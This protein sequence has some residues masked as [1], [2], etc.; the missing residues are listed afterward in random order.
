VSGTVSSATVIANNIS[1][2]T[3]VSTATVFASTGIITNLSVLSTIS[4]A[5]NMITNNHVSAA[6]N[7]TFAGTVSA[8]TAI[9]SNISATIGLSAA[10]IVVNGAL[11]VGGASILTGATVVGGS[12]SVSGITVLNSTMSVSGLSF[13]SSNVGIGTAT[14]NARLEVNGHISTA[15][16]TFWVVDSTSA[17]TAADEFAY[18]PGTATYPMSII[19]SQ[20]IKAAAYVVQSDERIK[21]NLLT[22]DDGEALAQLRKIEPTK[23]NYIE[24]D[25]RTTKPVYGFIAQQVAEHFPEA[26]TKG[27]GTIPNIYSLGNVLNGV[28]SLTKKHMLSIEDRL[29]F[30]LRKEDGNATNRLDGK[31]LEIVDEYRF[32]MIIENN[33]HEHSLD[34]RPIFVIGKHV[35]NFHNLNKDYLFTINF[36]ATQELDRQTQSLTSQL[37]Q[38]LIENTE[39]R[40]KNDDL[41]N[42]INLLKD[43]FLQLM[44]AFGTS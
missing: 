41:Q 19:A 28:V 43:Q 1:G 3:Q 17:N 12:L 24:I 11:S 30:Y 42:Q 13:F 21:K 34:D 8:T 35:D 40:A 37:Q 15:F 38:L 31:V 7:G 16:T 27:P 6:G 18:I 23:Y 32:R 20:Y 2:L 25:H 33:F 36:A 22:I 39:M 9:A 44:N 26:I 4:V 5:G 10:A 14:P 29:A